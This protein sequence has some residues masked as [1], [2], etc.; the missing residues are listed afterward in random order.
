MGR[1]FVELAWKHGVSVIG[2]MEPQNNTNSA[3]EARKISNNYFTA[4]IIQKYKNLPPISFSKL[5][6]H[7]FS[8][9]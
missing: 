7:I 5:T 9:N 1:K 2:T 3:N 4:F 8:L 6:L